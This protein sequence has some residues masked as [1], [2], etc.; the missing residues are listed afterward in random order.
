MALAIG[1]LETGQRQ[2][3]VA[4]RLWDFSLNAGAT[5]YTLYIICMA[6]NT[7]NTSDSLPRIELPNPECTFPIHAAGYALFF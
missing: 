4:Y 7:I 1:S 5:K 6:F 3:V 2:R